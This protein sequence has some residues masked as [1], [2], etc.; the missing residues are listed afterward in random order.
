M[1]DYNIIEYA[2]ANTVTDSDRIAGKPVRRLGYIPGCGYARGRGSCIIQHVLIG[3][4]PCRPIAQP[5]RCGGFF[6]AG[7]GGA[8][9]WGCFAPP[10]QYNNNNNNKNTCSTPTATGI[11]SYVCGR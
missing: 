5:D 1:V 7:T 3:G 2:R 4:G 10:R 9:T 6:F 11:R 8:R